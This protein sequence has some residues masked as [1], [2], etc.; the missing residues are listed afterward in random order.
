MSAADARTRLV[1]PSTVR[2]AA[3]VLR[4]SGIAGMIVTSIAESIDGALAFGFLGATGALTLLIVGLIVPAVEAAAT[5]DEEQAESVEAGIQRLGAAGADEEEVRITV[6]AAIEM[7]RRS[8][9]D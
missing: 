5:A 2:G 4:A 1:A 9:G 3:L 6:R 8:T 7:G